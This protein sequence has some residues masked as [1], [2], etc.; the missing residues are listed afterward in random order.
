MLSDPRKSIIGPIAKRYSIVNLYTPKRA[1][2]SIRAGCV[3]RQNTLQADEIDAKRSVRSIP[4]NVLPI[5]GE[6][7]MQRQESRINLRDTLEARMVFREVLAA[8]LAIFNQSQL[9]WSFVRN[10]LHF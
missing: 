10:V 7:H 2:S 9:I 5:T 8:L 4:A 6:N 3:C 1:G